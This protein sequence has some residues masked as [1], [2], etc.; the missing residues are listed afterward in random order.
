MSNDQSRDDESFS[1][2]LRE[3][4]RDLEHLKI[5]RGNLSLRRIEKLSTRTKDI[6][7]LPIGTLSPIFR[8]IRLPSSDVMDSLIRLLLSLDTHGVQR[9]VP[10]R[11]D[12][13]VDQWRSRWVELEFL[14][15]SEG[16][17]EKSVDERVSPEAVENSTPVGDIFKYKLALLEQKSGGK[18]G[19]KRSASSDNAVFA[20]AMVP[21]SELL[22]HLTYEGLRDT[23]LGLLHARKITLLTLEAIG[24]LLSGRTAYQIRLYGFTPDQERSNLS[25]TQEPSDPSSAYLDSLARGA[26]SRAVSDVQRDPDGWRLPISDSYRSAV[27]YPLRAADSPIGLLSMEGEKAR[28]LDDVSGE[29]IFRTLANALAAALAV[30]TGSVP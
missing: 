29:P 13:E 9:S 27:F 4:A 25:G 21:I 15:K 28:A 24:E 1:A 20:A 16:K 14:R 12:S 6:R 5:D 22:A 2:L 30:R 23:S 18:A 10:S 3:F 19:I 11:E 26:K 17:I 7:R 8:G